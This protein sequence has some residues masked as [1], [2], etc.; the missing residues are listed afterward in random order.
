MCWGQ[1]FYY[2]EFVEW[3]RFTLKIAKETTTMCF[4]LLS[5]SDHWNL[6]GWYRTFWHIL[7]P[8][9][10][11]TTDGGT[12]VVHVLC[13]HLGRGH[14]GTAQKVWIY[15]TLLVP[16]YIPTNIQY[17]QDS[18]HQFCLAH[19]ILNMTHLDTTSWIATRVHVANVPLFLCQCFDQWTLISS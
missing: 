12:L 19:F 18:S 16:H 11:Y 6:F 7:V 10:L 13:M 15:E 9:T 3:N 1:L 5:V 14:T 8:T 17:Y 2:L 4:S